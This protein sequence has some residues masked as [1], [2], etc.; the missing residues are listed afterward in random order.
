MQVNTGQVAIFD[1]I[2][3]GAGCAGLSL[4]LRMQESP[5]FKDKKILLIDA[6][7][8]TKNDRTWCFWETAPGLFQDI[9]CKEWKEIDFY[10]QSFSARFDI[11]PY[12]YKMIRGGDLYRY[13]FDKMLSWTNVVFRKEKAERV[14]SE[15]GQGYVHTNSGV[16][17]ARY[18]FNSILFQPERLQAKGSLL[19]H[20]KGW[21]ITTEEDCFNSEV[22]TFMDFRLRPAE[23][24]TFIYV[25][26]LSSRKAL[27]EYTVFSSSLLADEAYT[28]GLAAYIRQ[29]L[30]IDKYT[31]GEEEFG[32]IPMSTYRF[33]QQ[34]DAVVNIGT[35]GGQ[36]K[37]S[38]GYTFQFIQKHSTD[39]VKALITDEHPGSKHSVFDNRFSVYDATLLKVLYNKKRTA[40]QVFSDLFQHNKPQLLFKFLDN[41]T[42]LKEELKIM[43]SVP[44]RIFLPAAL[45]GLL[46][47]V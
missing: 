13:V 22:A 31:V 36:T 40:S 38:S 24:N 42:T 44:T 12:V 7:D 41:E 17:A 5:F 45:K 23:E 43:N 16:Y 19:Q 29:Y 20:F 21:L 8:K 26:P 11:V 39:I 9:V 46:Q 1:Y 4:L 37:G 30:N 18:V 34:N 3:T 6:T 15:N 25:L 28:N 2:I 10:G 14:Y 47:F 27:V 32:V 33:Q 35:A